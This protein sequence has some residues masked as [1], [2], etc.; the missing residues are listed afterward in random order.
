MNKHFEEMQ[1]A[2]KDSKGLVDVKKQRMK[3]V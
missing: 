1:K 3:E 2:I